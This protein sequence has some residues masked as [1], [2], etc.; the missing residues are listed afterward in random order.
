MAT[1]HD[2]LDALMADR[3]SRGMS[4]APMPAARTET[5][6]PSAWLEE[7]ESKP[8]AAIVIGLRTPNDKDYQTALAEPDD[9]AI[10]MSIVSVG[11]CDPNDVRRPHPSFPMPDI[12]IRALKP[13]TIRYLF[14]RIESLHIETSP[15]VPL[16]TDEELFI[17]GDALETGTALD[18]LT[19]VNPAAAARVRRLATA[20]FD[21]LRLDLTADGPEVTIAIGQPDRVSASG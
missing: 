14:D 3:A 7:A 21:A 11:I 2:N 19:A 15:S 8:V 18:R 6:E 1:L 4:S 20:L 10:M 5:L 9:T 16:A 17:L 13:A 12:Q